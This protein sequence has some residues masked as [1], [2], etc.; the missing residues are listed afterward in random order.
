MD[1][2]FGEKAF[3]WSTAPYKRG[4]LRMAQHLTDDKEIHMELAK[5]RE[6]VRRDTLTGAYT[7]LALSHDMQ[8]ILCNKREED[9]VNMSMLFIDLDDFKNI[10]DSGGHAVGDRI[11]RSFVEFL[12]N[13]IRERDRLYRY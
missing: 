3:R 13:N 4:D 2:K 6:F 9:P 12:Q 1:T 8:E 11:L 10:N 7:R 5:M